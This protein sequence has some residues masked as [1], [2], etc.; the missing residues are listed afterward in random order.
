MDENNQDDERPQNASSVKT[1]VVGAS[2]YL[3]RRFLRVYRQAH[4]DCVGTAFSAGLPDLRSFDI[5]RPDLTTLQLEE[6]GHRAVLIASAKSNV[7][8]CDREKE[9]AYAVNVKGTLELVRQI[10]RTS[11]QLIFLSSDYVF[12]GRTGSYDDCAELNPTTEYGRHKA[13]VEKEIPSLSDNYLILRLSK[14][15]GIQKGEGTLLDEIA[16]NLAGGRRVLAARDQ[17]FCPTYVEELIP[18]VLTI[19]SRDLRGVMNVCSP[20]AWSR[21]DMAI[22]MASAMRVDP[23][24]VEP[25]LLHDLPGMASRPLNIS[26]VCSRLSREVGGTFTPLE[27]C[28][29]QLAANWTRHSLIDTGQEHG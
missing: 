8:F 27:N 17:V 16:G 3:G 21:C 7:A 19:Q 25:I 9:A 15:F 4:P 5:R 1:A 18:I 2:G 24:L 23:G 29:E 11:M 13:I 22:R 14:I 28:I 26:M 20:E 6:T 12:D 10:G